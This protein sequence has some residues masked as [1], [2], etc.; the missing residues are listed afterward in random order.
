LKLILPELEQTKRGTNSKKIAVDY[1]GNRTTKALK[2]F[3]ARRMPDFSQRVTLG[4][5]EMAV[6]RAH[7]E[8]YSL[9]VAMWFTHNSETSTFSK[10]LST[11][12]RGR[13]VMVEIESIENNTGVLEEYGFSNSTE[14]PE[15]LIMPANSVWSKESTIRYEEDKFT[16]AQLKNFVSQYVVQD[17]ASNTVTETA[18]VVDTDVVINI[19]IAGEPDEGESS[20]NELSSLSLEDKVDSKRE[21]QGIESPSLVDPTCASI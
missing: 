20:L 16:I 19:P 6:V 21:I 1:K 17:A 10:F 14:F 8:Q 4:E 15:L 12:F 18:Q 11:E 5:T 2:S 9:P 3:L 13:L 7:A